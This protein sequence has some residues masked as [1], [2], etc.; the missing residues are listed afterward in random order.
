MRYFRV[1]MEAPYYPFIEIEADSEKEAREKSEAY[2]R[3]NGIPKD[4]FLDSAEFKK[5]KCVTTTPEGKK[6]YR[7]IE[8]DSDDETC[9]FFS[10]REAAEKKFLE[11]IEGF[12]KEKAKDANGRTYKQCRDE[13]G[14]ICYTRGSEAYSVNVDE[15]VLDCD[16]WYYE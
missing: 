4:N 10:T 6:I 14:F 8:D 11:L 15:I 12:V 13:L 2:E 3:E 1:W 9:T 7:L 16:E 5:H